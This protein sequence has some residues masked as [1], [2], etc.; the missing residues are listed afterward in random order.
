MKR[1]AFVLLLMSVSAC[2]KYPQNHFI[3]FRSE[4]ARLF[5][6]WRMTSYMGYNNVTGYYYR[7]EEGK[8]TIEEPGDVNT[9]DMSLK[10]H[11]TEIDI[12]SGGYALIKY[13][14]LKLTSHKLALQVIDA[15]DVT[16]LFESD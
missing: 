12:S 7:F 11:K 16:L 3:S 2:E 4:E 5:Q 9:F 14:I 8:V 1:I 6:R 15:P 13:K 10:E